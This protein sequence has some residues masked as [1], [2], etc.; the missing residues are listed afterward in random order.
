MDSV[1]KVGLFVV[2]RCEDDEVDDALQCLLKVSEGSNP[3]LHKT[4]RFELFRI[5]LNSF[6][7]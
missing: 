4:Y 7:V 6:S 1:E 2:V 3:R 5:V